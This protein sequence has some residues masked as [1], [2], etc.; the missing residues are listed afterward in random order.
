MGKLPKLLGKIVGL[1]VPVAKFLHHGPPGD[2]R[3]SGCRAYGLTCIPCMYNVYMN[4]YIQTYV[5]IYIDVHIYNMHIH[6]YVC[7]YVCMHV[8]IEAGR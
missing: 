1:A 2:E 5:Y 6:M 4:I 8:C 7:M 3:A